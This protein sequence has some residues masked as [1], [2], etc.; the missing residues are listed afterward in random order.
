MTPTLRTYNTTLHII[1]LNRV[2]HFLIHGSY[3][4][5]GFHPYR[6]NHE[7]Y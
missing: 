5:E 4:T 1:T 2:G 6:D 3:A 7:S